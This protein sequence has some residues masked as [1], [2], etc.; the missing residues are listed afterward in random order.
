MDSIIILLHYVEHLILIISH[1]T[2]DCFKLDSSLSANT[3]MTDLT[4][5]VQLE[6]IYQNLTSHYFRKLTYDALELGPATWEM[7]TPSVNYQL[8]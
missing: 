8:Q 5:Q 2:D 1:P 3:I 7:C 4:N 6:F